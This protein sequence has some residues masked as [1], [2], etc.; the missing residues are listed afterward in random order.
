MPSIR[1]D[2]VI[3]NKIENFIWLDTYFVLSARKV[4]AMESPL[5]G[6]ERGCNYNIYWGGGHCEQIQILGWTPT[7]CIIIM[8]MTVCVRECN[9]VKNK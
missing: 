2:D 9:N 6:E 7:K 1:R 4:V 3:Q 8:T 5:G